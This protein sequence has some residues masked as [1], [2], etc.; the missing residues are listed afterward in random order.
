LYYG[1]FLAAALVAAAPTPNATDI[2]RN[3]TL[4]SNNAVSVSNT[5][6][7]HGVT[8]IPAVGETAP[9]F[10][11]QSRDYLW[12]N[13]HNILEQGDVLLVFGAN[14]EQLRAIERDQEELLGR[15]IV[16]IA[17]VG[18][19]ESEVWRT[20]RR[21]G[22][23]YSLLADPHAAIAEQYGAIDAAQTSRPVWFVIDRTGH[24]RGAGEGATM[25]RD[26]TAA[27]MS[28]LGRSDVQTASAH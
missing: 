25:P 26:W 5:P 3:T 2:V 22:L 12:Q 11:Y 19:R 6:G 28:A 10:T 23:S 16:P 21:D 7:T 17:V 15:G 24:V 18:Q 27:A 9:D 14:D 8:R 13:L 20:V 4:A 1:L